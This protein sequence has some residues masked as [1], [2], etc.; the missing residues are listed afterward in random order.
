MGMRLP[1]RARDQNGRLVECTP[2]QCANANRRIICNNSDFGHCRIWPYE[3]TEF[4]GLEIFETHAFGTA[5]RTTRAIPANTYV[6]FYPGKIGLGKLKPS[7]RFGLNVAWNL[8]V[9]TTTHGALARFF[10]HSCHRLD[11]TGRLY[12][13]VFNWNNHPL[14]T[15]KTAEYSIPAMTILTINYGPE[16]NVSQFM[17]TKCTD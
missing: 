15:F 17:C 16:Y 6:C 10:T 12:M 4:K 3:F 7:T 2:A 13:R 8:H 5:V 14:V 1:M 11:Q 9:D